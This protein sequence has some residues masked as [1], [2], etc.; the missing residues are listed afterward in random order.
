MMSIT[1]FRGVFAREIK[2]SKT[3]PNISLIP[4]HA[5]SQF[6]ENTPVIKSIMP[7]NTFLTFPQIRFTVP[8][9]VLST[10]PNM[11]KLFDQ[12]VANTP[13]IKSIN[14]VK[15]YF[16]RKSNTE[17]A[18]VWNPSR[19]CPSPSQHRLK[20]SVNA[21][22]QKSRNPPR[23]SE[24]P[25]NT[26][27]TTAR[28]SRMISPIPAMIGPSTGMIVFTIHSTKGTRA[29]SHKAFRLSKILPSRSAIPLRAGCTCSAH[30]VLNFSAR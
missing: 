2:L 12:S 15:I 9:N 16:C 13:F 25:L 10:C 18:I 4:F 28:R 17:P 29:V 1:A 6:P 7:L 5:R 20:S 22:V 23:I 21:P 8:R 26:S 30:T 3:P 11:P 24:I 27:P 19:I 14:G